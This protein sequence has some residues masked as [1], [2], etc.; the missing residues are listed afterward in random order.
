V[1]Y[2]EPQRVA[3]ARHYRFVAYSQRS[4]ADA[5]S[6][7]DDLVGLMRSRGEGSVHLVGFSSAVALRATVRAPELVR[8]LTIIEPNVPWL[9]EGDAEGEAVLSAWRAS[10]DRLRAEAGADEDRRAE[11]WFELVNNRGPGI[12]AKEP[13][14]FRQMWLDN[15]GRP[16]ATAPPK[17]LRCADLGK[18]PVPTLALGAE[19]GMRYSRLIVDRLVTCIPGAEKLIVIGT[20]HFMSQQMPGAFNDV[21]L[22]F[23]GRH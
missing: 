16:R 5:E 22:G 19:Y 12:F 6:Q 8:S 21:V 3:F 14:T 20:T 7:A 4:E 23:I 1:R 18:I 15:F 2:W 11:L 13:A 17:P 10:N 9:L